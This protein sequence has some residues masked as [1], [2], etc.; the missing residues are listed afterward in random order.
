MFYLSIVNKY[1]VTVTLG[2]RDSSGL[3]IIVTLCNDGYNNIA[4]IVYTANYWAL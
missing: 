2:W 3:H 1:Y 4:Y